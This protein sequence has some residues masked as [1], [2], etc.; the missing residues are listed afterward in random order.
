MITKNEATMLPDML[1]SVAGLWDELIVADTGSTDGTVDLLKTHGAKIIDH[2]WTDDFAAARNTSIA[3][4]TG[5][6]V[7][8]LDADERATPELCQQIKTLMGD[9][10]IGAATVVMRNALPGGEYREASLLRLFRNHAGVTFRHKIHEDVLQDVEE[11]LLRKNLRAQHLE[12]VVHHLGYVREVASAKDKRQRDQRLLRKVLRDDPRDFY[13]WFKLLE[14]ARYWQDTELWRAAATQ[15]DPILRGELSDGERKSLMNN[16]WSGEL[17]ALISRGLPIGPE[18]ALI[19]LDQ[20][21]SRVRCSSAWHLQRGLWS[22]LLD[23]SSDAAEAFASC[24][25]DKRGSAN[26]HHVRAHLGLSRLAAGAGN[27]TQASEW[28]MEALKS[29]PRDVEAVLAVISFSPQSLTSFVDSQVTAHPDSAQV[30]AEQLIGS[31]N[32]KLAQHLLNEM[33]VP[34]PH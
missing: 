4:A 9:E 15:V 8:F 24:L 30:W 16:H 13:C 11:L 1:R 2:V 12:G 31:G 33:S 14:S 28:A 26:H 10:S 27:L 6:W 18:Q 3:S 34:Q 19:W 23:R 32:I 17:A 7:L 20:T 22:E 5:D 29:A 25:A 21:K